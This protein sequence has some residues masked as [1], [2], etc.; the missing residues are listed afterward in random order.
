MTILSIRK[1]IFYLPIT[2]HALF[3]PGNTSMPFILSTLPPILGYQTILLAVGLGNGVS[4][5][6]ITIEEFLNSF[7]VFEHVIVG[8]PDQPGI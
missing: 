7:K 4:K 2:I 8:L 3:S 5:K 6:F 1:Y